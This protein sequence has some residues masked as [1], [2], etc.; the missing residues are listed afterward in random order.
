MA[1]PAHVMLCPGAGG[2]KAAGL[3]LVHSDF[4][5]DFSAGAGACED[6]PG[7]RSEPR[8]LQLPRHELSCFDVQVLAARMLE[9][10]QLCDEKHK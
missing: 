10:M 6:H 3:A 4:G 1:E 8:E 2:A 9:L 5:H 7:L